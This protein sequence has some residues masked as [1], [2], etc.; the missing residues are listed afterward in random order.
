MGLTRQWEE[1]G[2]TDGRKQG[3]TK[4]V[5]NYSVRPLDRMTDPNSFPVRQNKKKQISMGAAEEVPLQNVSQTVSD[6]HKHCE[7]TPCVRFCT[8]YTAGVFE[9][10]ESTKDGISGIQL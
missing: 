8:E 10:G 3:K 5:C 7:C 9:T 2:D 4:R 6:T 1:R